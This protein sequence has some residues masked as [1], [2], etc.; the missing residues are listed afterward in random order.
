MANGFTV[1]SVNQSQE[2]AGAGNLQ[3]V[4]VVQFELD[5]NAG[6]GEVRVPLTGDWEAAAVAAIQQ[7]AAA[8]Q[9]LLNL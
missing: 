2:I 8:M 5:N 6:S 9:A 4:V 1:T 3:D 7:K